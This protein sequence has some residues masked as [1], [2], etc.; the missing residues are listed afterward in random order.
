VL[1]VLKQVGY[2][3]GLERFIALCVIIT[4]NIVNLHRHS[5]SIDV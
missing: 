5:W 4:L 1:S 2:T 3:V